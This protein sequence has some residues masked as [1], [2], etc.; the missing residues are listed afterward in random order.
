[1]NKHCDRLVLLLPTECRIL[2]R[3]NFF[4]LINQ[5]NAVKKGFRVLQLLK[6]MKPPLKL[7]STLDQSLLRFLMKKEECASIVFKTKRL[8]REIRTSTQAPGDP[9]R[10]LKFRQVRC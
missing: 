1:M 7:D 6:N 9:L 2:L 10:S 3:V 8:A 4:L 5:E